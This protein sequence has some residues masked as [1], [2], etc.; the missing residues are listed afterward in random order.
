MED[1]P[2]FCGLLRISELKNM[3]QIIPFWKLRS[4]YFTNEICKNRSLWCQCSMRQA[5]V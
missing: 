4:G 1:W 3:P 5:G 2:N